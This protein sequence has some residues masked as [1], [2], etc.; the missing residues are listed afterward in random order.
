MNGN[1]LLAS[2]RVICLKDY[3]DF[4]GIKEIGDRYLLLDKKKGRLV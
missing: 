3:G 2:Q 4:L 1:H